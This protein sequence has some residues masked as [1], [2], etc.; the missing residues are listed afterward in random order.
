[1]WTKQVIEEGQFPGIKAHLTLEATVDEIICII[2]DLEH[3]SKWNPNVDLAEV[4]VIVSPPV[5]LVARREQVIG[6]RFLKKDGHFSAV[7]KSMIHDDFPDGRD[8]IVR[9]E[10]LI[11]AMHVSQIDEKHVM[12]QQ[13]NQ[14]NINGWIPTWI[15]SSLQST[16]TKKLIG[17]M[18]GACKYY[19]EN[20]LVE[21]IS[22]QY[23]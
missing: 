14:T 1:M 12:I 6:R 23:E 15:S 22:K 11:S 10:V 2:C 16:V 20:N 7:M 8:G 18:P 17:A 3:R 21:K 4:H 9:T 5:S 19:R 13:I